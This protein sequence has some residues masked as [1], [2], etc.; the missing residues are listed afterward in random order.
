MTSIRTRKMIPSANQ[1]LKHL[2]THANS[3]SNT[4]HLVKILLFFFLPP[5]RTIKDKPSTSK[6]SLLTNYKSTLENVKTPELCKYHSWR[7]M[8]TVF[9]FRFKSLTASSLNC[10]T[11][12]RE[13]YLQIFKNFSKYLINKG[14]RIE[15]CQT[16]QQ[17]LDPD[18]SLIT[19]EHII[20]A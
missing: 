17:K 6:A 15:Q 18:P 19:G 12:N 11:V 1:L 13:I 2:K 7:I 20:N 3:F 8:K 10:Q 14:H 5:P 9:S 16:Q 4:Y